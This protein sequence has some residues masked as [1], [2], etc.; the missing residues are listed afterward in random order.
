V[1]TIPVGLLG[2]GN[3]G[4]GVV[5][6]LAENDAALAARLGARL[7][8]KAVAVRDLARPRQVAVDAG[9]LTTDPAAGC[10][11]PEIR[12]V[13]ELMGGLEP[14]TGLMLQAITAGKHVVTA[15]K[16]ALAEHGDELFAAAAA[17]GV[18][19]YYEAAVCGGLPIIRALREGLASDRIQEV[20][21]IVNG[22]SNF[23]LTAMAE[24]G[25][26]FDEVLR[27]AQAAGYAEADPSFDVDGVDACHKLTLLARLS[28]GARLRPEQILR[29][30]I[31]QVTP[32]DLTLAARFGYVVKPL[33][34]ADDDGHGVL[35]RVHPALVPT[36]DPLASCAGAM[37]AV[38]VT[39]RALGQSLYQGR[40]AGMMPTAVAVVADL[41]EVCRD[42]PA[43]RVVRGA[44][45]SRA[46]APG[47][48]P[49]PPRPLRDP[50]DLE[51]RYYLRFA[52][53]DRPGV[54]AQVTRV[55]GEH[56][57]SI[58]QLVQEGAPGPGQP[59]A[60]VVVTHPA[61]E[62]HVRSA[63]A[64]IDGLPVVANPTLL[65]RIQG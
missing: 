62:R 5:K 23:I 16:H 40:G 20:V 37:N 56:E 49:P 54:L 43:A 11:D 31:R 59:A 24:E 21:G 41:I 28:F 34:I 14:A 35:A 12:V 6:L 50:G 30:G 38:K 13:V 2:L 51:C 9:L 18:N 58:W 64:T 15:N 1:R 61:R 22:T 19:V 25:R 53:A 48:P 55:L 60:V 7:A 29:D 36:R 26:P 45:G 3:V 42:L 32:A 39:S 4:A 63:L 47:A 10:A 33:A 27:D 44:D 65:L 52:A 8:I 57:I 17:A 46:P